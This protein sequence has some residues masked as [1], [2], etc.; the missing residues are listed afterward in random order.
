M[1]NY[2]ALDRRRKRGNVEGLN[3]TTLSHAHRVSKNTISALVRGLEEQGLV[4]RNLEPT[5]FR[6]FRIQLTDTGRE[7]ITKSGPGRVEK[8][9]Q[10]AKH[11]TLEERNQLIN[12]LIKLH[13]SL[14]EISMSTDVDGG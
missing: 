12:L 14:T 7:L 11:M 10:L 9:N 6:K 3:P 5:D 4:Q 1:E 13:H 8:Y 2:A